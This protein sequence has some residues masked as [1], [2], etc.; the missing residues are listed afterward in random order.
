S[1]PSWS[2]T[3]FQVARRCFLYG[4]SDEF[5]ANFSS[6]VDR[7]ADHVAAIEA[8]LV[9]ESGFVS[10]RLRERAVKLIEL[11]GETA[12]ETKKILSQHYGIRSTLVHGS[13]LS[14]RQM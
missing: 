8:A 13:P 9:P 1:S 2:S 7:V 10:R 11:E 14:Q 3:W 5:N 4:S 12:R 6:E